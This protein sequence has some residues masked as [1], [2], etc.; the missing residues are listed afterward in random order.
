MLRVPSSPDPLPRV[1][2]LPLLSFLAIAHPFGAV[3]SILR[4]GGGGRYP[5][6]TRPRT[7]RPLRPPGAPGNAGHYL[8]QGPVTANVVPGV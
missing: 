8:L 3:L 1:S 6:R 2:F 4:R 5:R 7:R